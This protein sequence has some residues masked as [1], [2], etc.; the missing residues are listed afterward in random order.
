MPSQSGEELR[1]P[2]VAKST[3]KGR[4]S[5]GSRR[6]G[7]YVRA[8]AANPSGLRLERVGMDAASVAWA[9]CLGW[10]SVGFFSISDIRSAPKDVESVPRPGDL[11]AVAS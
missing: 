9:R 2:S 11:T 1:K 3:S 5:H 6:A 4:L 8:G 10:R 7:L